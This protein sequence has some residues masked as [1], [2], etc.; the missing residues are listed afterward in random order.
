MK[1][2]MKKLSMWLLAVVAGVSM[3]AVVS[4]S[5]DDSDDNN[6]DVG[7]TDPSTIAADNL[8]AYFPFEDNGNDAKGGLSPATSTGVSYVTGMKGK[9]YQG[10]GEKGSGGDVTGDSSY[11]HY[12]LPASSKLRDLQ[13]FSFSMWIKCVA[14]TDGGPEPM[15][16]QIDGTTDF[17]WGNLFFLQQRNGAAADSAVLTTYFWKN[18]I[19]PADPGKQGQRAGAKLGNFFGKFIHVIS[20]YDNTT[21]KYV[22]YVDGAKFDGGT[23][24]E[25]RTQGTDG[26]SLGNLK[27]NE[28]E[29]LTIGA[30]AA[31]AKGNETWQWAGFFKG[32]IDEFRIYDR[33]LTA[34]EA[35]ALYKAEF[36]A[37]A[38]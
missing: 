23:A 10:N 13:A 11:L 4:C 2:D 29:T 9:A 12:K 36:V 8:I 25:N 5:D 30:W 33:A 35:D 28:A 20:T 32:N 7:K 27:F 26:P 37:T 16:F 21:S 17:T 22:L 19:T 15:I 24:L 18:D 1:K 34:D 38:E 31:V 3:S 14:T 6:T